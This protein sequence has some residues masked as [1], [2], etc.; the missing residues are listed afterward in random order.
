MSQSSLEEQFK[1]A[2]IPVKRGVR[3]IAEK[4]PTRSKYGSNLWMHRWAANSY[5]NYPVVSRAKG[6]YYLMD[7]CKGLPC[8]IVGV[9]PSLD[10]DVDKLKRA[11]GHSI[12][13]ATDAS[14]RVLMAKGIRPD[15]VI[16]Y[17]C[18]PEQ[19]LLW[20][21]IPGEHGVPAL[22]DT[23]AHPNAIASWKGPVLFYNHFHQTDELSHFI[24]PFVFPHIG[25]IPSGA[26]VGN[27]ALLLSNI[28]GASITIAV[29][30]DF[31]YGYGEKQGKQGWRY[32]ATDYRWK[33]DRAA[34]VPDG[35][36][37]GETTVLYDNDERVGRSFP[38]K[39]KDVEFRMDP[40][41]SF[42]HEVFVN[43]VNHFGIA[44]VNTATRGALKDLV[45]TMPIDEAITKYCTDKKLAE[46]R[47]VLSH[48]GKL[49]T[50]PREK[51]PAP[52]F[53]KD[54]ADIRPLSEA[55]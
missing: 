27:A 7:A 37:K 16:S 44:T 1:E 8:F 26:T 51:T 4:S 11:V 10:D 28:M 21:D 36:E 53:F 41:L 5:R 39:I 38:T 50:D 48:L 9:G 19:R 17:D 54:S 6:V 23:C 2:G 29:G 35:W 13:I 43:F 3:V 33:T 22:F 40:E 32:R 20:E 12:I 15:L 55:K 46:G 24:L 49:I 14:F 52:M 30:M 34:G 25:Q 47:T 45:P 31:C 18:K 42:Y